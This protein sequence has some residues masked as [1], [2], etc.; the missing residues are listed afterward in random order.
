MQAGEVMTLRELKSRLG[1]GEHSVRQARREGLQL[2]RFG[3]AKY[4]LGR[5]LLD[6]FETLAQRQATG[7]GHRAEGG[8][9]E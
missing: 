5:D 6:F 3:R 4:C 8:D 9:D 1:W 7:N 2:V